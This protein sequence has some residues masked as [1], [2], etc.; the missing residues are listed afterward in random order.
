[1]P[2]VTPF[3]PPIT[4]PIVH[5]VTAPHN[6]HKSLLVSSHGYR[7]ILTGNTLLPDPYIHHL[8]LG[9]ENPKAAV[10][11]LEAAYHKAG[12]FLVAIKATL[13]G[14]VIQIQ[15]IQGQLTKVNTTG[16]LGAFFTGIR[17]RTNLQEN[18]IVYQS[19][20]ANAFAQRNGQRMQIGFGPSS[21]PGGSQM[22]VS[23]TPIP[24]YQALV[25]N[26]F[27]GN[28]GSRYS[29]RYLTGGSVSYSPGLGLNLSINGTQGLASL[30]PSSKGSDYSQGGINA[31]SITPWGVYSFNAQWV[32]YRTGEISYPVNPTGN[33]F[34]WGISG[35]QLLYANDQS[36]WSLIEGFNH[37]SN[38][39]KIY[40]GILPG[41]YPLTIQHYGYWD[42]GSRWNLS[43]NLLQKPGSL[44]ASLTY[45]QGVS[46]S[47]GTLYSH[48][49]GYP[50]AQFRYF[51]ANI[52][53][54]QTL[55]FGLSASFSATGQGAFNTLPQ[56]NQWVLG[57]FGNLSAFYPGVLVGD[58]GYSAR[59]QLQS[60]S[61]SFY[62]FNATAN[63]FAEAGGTTY[64]YL[65]RNQSPWQS[66]SDVGIGL[67]MQSP[68]GTNISV[69]SALPTGWNNVSASVRK[70]DR[71]DAYFVLS[72]NF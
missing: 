65:A 6:G 44:N 70:A 64:T 30:T 3:I 52:A 22:N 58:S 17:Y 60:P 54:S 66:L 46:A 63:L 15:I 29:G 37:V 1:M 56:Q 45:N 7:Y 67:N 27:F 16:H 4:P 53:T 38:Q 31:S 59:F 48:I 14:K 8:L 42:I 36:R 32:H 10:A 20:L 50:T 21:N 40:Q 69:I 12:Y 13:K 18:N 26:V 34:T 68:W 19:I 71:V 72:Q 28:Y 5:Q 47:R 55:P 35:S 39:V 23:E 41:G 25:G 57:G 24:G 43:Y 49:P 11:A 33:I 62:G 2:I 61:W 51:V 9:V